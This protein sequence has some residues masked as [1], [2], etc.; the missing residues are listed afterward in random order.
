META[1][2]QLGY[3]ELLATGSNASIVDCTS[4]SVTF[5]LTQ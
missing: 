1:E 2:Q 3:G 5:T 4:A